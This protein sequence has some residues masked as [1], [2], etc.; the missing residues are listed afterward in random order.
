MGVLLVCAARLTMHYRRS[1]SCACVCAF[2]TPF[3]ITGDVL[4]SE[5]VRGLFR[6]L[7]STLARE[8]P[9][10]FFFFGGNSLVKSALTPA[11]KTE[12]ELSKY[13]HECRLYALSV[14][15][16]GGGGG[17]VVCV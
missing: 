16:G 9:G 3:Q 10:N 15:G 2:R 6:G 4:R 14:Y 1:I 7:T 8:V 17:Y 11:G 13:V 5:G 12:S